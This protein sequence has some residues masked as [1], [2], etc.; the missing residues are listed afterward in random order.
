M[1]LRLFTHS[2]GQ[3][4]AEYTVLIVAAVSALV[5]M[6]ATIRSSLAGRMKRGADSVGHGMIYRR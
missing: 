3:S 5:A 4:M 1:A 2:R 6:F